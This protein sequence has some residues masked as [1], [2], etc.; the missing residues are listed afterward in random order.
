MAVFRCV[1]EGGGDDQNQ[2]EEGRAGRERVMKDGGRGRERSRNIE[3]EKNR[4]ATVAEFRGKVKIKA[5]W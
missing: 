5:A 2:R 1:E 3:F 4:S